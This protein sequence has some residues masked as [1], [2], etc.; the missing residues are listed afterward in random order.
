MDKKVKTTIALQRQTLFCYC[1]CCNTWPRVESIPSTLSLPPICLSVSGTNRIC[2]SV[3]E[4]FDHFF[5]P[6]CFIYFLSWPT[7]RLKDADMSRLIRVSGKF[8]FSRNFPIIFSSLLTKNAKSHH[9]HQLF[10]TS[11]QSP[12]ISW[13]TDIYFHYFFKFFRLSFCSLLAR[14]ILQNCHL[15]WEKRGFWFATSR[16]DCPRQFSSS[17]A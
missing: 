16:A 1:S 3:L 11:S 13:R 14:C 15:K 6:F 17:T 4:P 12:A 7:E 10:R 8:L 5:F 9:F 2:A